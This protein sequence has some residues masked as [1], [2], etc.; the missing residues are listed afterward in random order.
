VRTKADRGKIFPRKDRARYESYENCVFKYNKVA[1]GLEGPKKNP[2]GWPEYRRRKKITPAHAVGPSRVAL[3][4]GTHKNMPREFPRGQKKKSTGWAEYRH[5]KI[6]AYLLKKW[7][8]RAHFT[9][10]P[11]PKN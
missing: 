6:V 9:L 7:A 2:A 4:F 11:R 3:V 1:G 10:E 5:R 8:R